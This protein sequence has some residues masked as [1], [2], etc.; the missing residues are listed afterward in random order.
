MRCVESI[1][2]IIHFKDFDFKNVKHLI[3]NYVETCRTSGQDGHIGKHTLP[4][5]TATA[6][7]ATKLQNKYH[8]EFSENQSVWKSDNQGFKEA[9]FIQMA[10]RRGDADMSRE[11]ERLRQAQRGMKTQ[12]GMERH[13]DMEYAVPHPRVVDKQ[14]VIHLEQE[15]LVPDQN[16]LPSIPVPGR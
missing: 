3:K 6:K 13:G 12:S 11:A 15:I 16:T 14:G 2:Q 8:P 5:H 9:T 4:P 10:K 7:I 1:T